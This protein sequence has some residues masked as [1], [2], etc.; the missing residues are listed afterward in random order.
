VEEKKWTDLI[1]K[2]QLTTEKKKQNIFCDFEEGTINFMPSYRMMRH[3]EAWSNKRKQSPSYTDRI[4]WLS[5]KSC[6][7]NLTQKVYTRH[8]DVFGS[9]HRPVSAQFDLLVQKFYSGTMMSS[10]VV[11]SRQNPHGLAAVIFSEM[12]VTPVTAED[13]LFFPLLLR[14]NS[15]V[16][17]SEAFGGRLKNHENEGN[18]RMLRDELPPID[19][20]TFILQ[21][22]VHERDWLEKQNLIF[23]FYVL[24]EHSLVEQRWGH[25]V[26]SL[27]ESTFKANI[28]MAGRLLGECTG[29]LSLEAQ[30]SVTVASP[31]PK[32]V[33][34]A[35]YS[36]V[37]KTSTVPSGK[38]NLKKLF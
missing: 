37:A 17:L 21:P 33:P 36:I 9:D 11:R 24:S 8:G 3:E 12:T 6:R 1:D 16:L 18:W 4:L 13:N 30:Q 14:V 5:G 38:Y 15:S 22:Y 29:S 34:A 35:R 26:I 31:A 19:Q 20:G 27:A 7:A 23:T 25:C 2:D 32:L 28:T 10:Q